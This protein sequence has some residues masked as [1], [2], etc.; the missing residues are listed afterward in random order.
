MF[1]IRSLF[2]GT[3]ESYWR[4]GGWVHNGFGWVQAPASFCGA[5]SMAACKCGK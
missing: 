2:S 1:M 3:A 5:K 4:P